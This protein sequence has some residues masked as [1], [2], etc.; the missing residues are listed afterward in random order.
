MKKYKDR[1]LQ[2]AIKWIALSSTIY[3]LRNAFLCASK[4]KICLDELCLNFKHQG[5]NIF[6]DH[7][8]E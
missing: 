4:L 3:L 7:L 5:Y 2:L 8:E 1:V 6:D